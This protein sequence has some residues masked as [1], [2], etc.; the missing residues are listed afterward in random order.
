VNAGTLRRRIRDFLPAAL[1]YG[2]ITLFSSLERWPVE[3]GWSF[4]DKIAHALIFVPL[5]A[6]LALGFSRGFSRSEACRFGGPVGVGAGLAVL[7][8]FHQL[9][10]PGRRA[11]PWDFLADCVGIVLGA[12]AFRVFGVLAAGRRKR[13]ARSAAAASGVDKKA[14]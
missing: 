9:F 7:D 10:V 3:I 13:S 4:F 6:F 8:E 1:H 11:S 14:G 12:A 2:L 5:G